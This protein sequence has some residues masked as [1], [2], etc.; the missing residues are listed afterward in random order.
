MTPLE[1]F[2]LGLMAFGAI[3]SLVAAWGIL[4]FPTSLARMHAA[5]KPASLGL[6]T[7]T[8]GAGVAAGSWPLLGVGVLVTAF[9]FVT[10]PM[11]GHMLGRASYLAGQTDLVHDDLTGAD[12]EPPAESHR[13]APWTAVVRLASIVGVWMLLWG[14]ASVGTL[15]GG[16]LVAGLHTIARTGFGD[17]AMLR[18]RSIIPFVL[19]YVGLLIRSNLR[20]AW[21][22]VTPSNEQIREAIVA[23]PLRTRSTPVAM[24]VANAV[25]FSPGSLTVEVGGDPMVLY[26][27]VLQ[28][29]T[30]AE[31]RAD[32]W[33]LEELID[34]GVVGQDAQDTSIRHPT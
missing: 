21:E 31:A 30:E 28:F 7:L 15:L 11:G 29:T 8:L 18:S 12:P 17:A 14:E 34:R 23:V 19:T 26:V 27:H 13:S 9:L 6:S 25:T 10:A 22:V 4:D 2:G 20:V 1:W 24:L 16:L 5:T 3:F 33:R 32:V